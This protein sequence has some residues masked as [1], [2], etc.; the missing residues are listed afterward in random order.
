MRFLKKLFG[1]SEETNI[2]KPINLEESYQTFW[3]WFVKNE[4]IFFDTVKKG[5]VNN[6]KRNFFSKLEPNL[7]KVLNEELFFL[8][9]MYDENTVELIFTAEGILKNF[10]F[11]EDLVEASPKLKN[12]KFTTHK[13]TERPS[14]FAIEMNGFK[15]D[16]NNISFYPNENAKY[17]DDIDLTFV[18]NDFT[19]ANEEAIAH[20][21]F[22]FLDNYIGEYKFVTTIDELKFT[23]GKEANQ[24]LIPI[25]KLDAFIDWREKEFVEKYDA[26]FYTNKNNEFS[27]YRLSADDGTS[28]I[29]TM[30]SN[31]LTWENKA[32]YPFLAIIDIEV[33]EHDKGNVLGDEELDLLE[34]FQESVNSNLQHKEHFLEIGRETYEINRTIYIACKD[35]R[36]ISKSIFEQKQIYKSKLK[37]DYKIVKDKYWK[38]LN[39]YIE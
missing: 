30:N 22:I 27:M 38:Y 31:L 4:R 14:E 5:G 29:A 19:S 2:S 16:D 3:L 36:A 26:V 28:M 37:I 20:G 18:H 32:S 17:P 24:D 12:W 1:K 8:T 39:N 6:L 35:F 23:D 9:G 21:I 15:F 13:Q 10:V 34:E 33:K 7:N 25:K 11:V